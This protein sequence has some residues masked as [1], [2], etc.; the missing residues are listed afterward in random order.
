MPR[1]ALSQWLRPL[2]PLQFLAVSASFLYP[3]LIDL[4]HQLDSRLPH[5]DYRI[6]SL[7]R[8]CNGSL[9]V[10]VAGRMHRDDGSPTI[11]L[12]RRSVDGG[13]TFS[14]A[15][16]LLEDPTNATS[17]GGVPVLDPATCDI[18]YM[19]N[20]ERQGPAC[21]S[22]WQ[23]IMRSSDDGV[24][25]SAPVRANT[26]GPPN[27]TWGGGL[28]HG[29]A[30]VR[31]PHVGRLLVPLRHDCGCGDLRASFVIYSDD[32]GA[33][34]AGGDKLVLL[35]ADGGGWTECEAAELKNGSVLLTS[36]NFYNTESGYGPRLFARSDDGGQTW[37]ANW[38]AAD[39]PDPYC[40]A[41][42]T[43]ADDG[44]LFFANPSNARGRYN[45][46]VHL[47]TD[48]GLTWPQSAVFYPGGAAYSDIQLMSDGSV[49]VVFER[50]NYNTIA[51][52][53]LPP[54]SR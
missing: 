45:L 46:S 51:F 41:S 15:T 11:Q 25:W 6:P 27:A 33:T 44:T 54:T 28:S 24:T 10:F 17:F 7:L 29:I 47:S 32:H 1:W 37:A 21:N 9:L 18:I 52:G 53:I 48:S 8:T 36:R 13:A 34:W 49:A 12:V 16:V 23:Y 35:P 20:Q 22:C 19:H 30:L 2:L 39:L 31:G 26:T 4:F 3:P 5:G 14:N 40:E 42:I 50:D 43:A 38:S